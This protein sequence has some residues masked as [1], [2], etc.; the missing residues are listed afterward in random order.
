ME[1]TLILALWHV[2]PVSLLAKIVMQHFLTVLL[3]NPLSFTIKITVLSIALME[4]IKIFRI[5][6]FAAIL[7]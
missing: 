4:L 7:A 1:P 2:K 5:V 6:R 3:A